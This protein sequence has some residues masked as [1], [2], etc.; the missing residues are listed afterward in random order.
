MNK[1]N[2]G[3]HQ[4]QNM[5]QN[6]NGTRSQGARPAGNQQKPANGSRGGGQGKK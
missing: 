6:G 3:Q 4:G 2:S 1:Q 5:E